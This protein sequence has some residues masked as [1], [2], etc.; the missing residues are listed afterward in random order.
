MVLAP[1]RDSDLYTALTGQLPVSV[2]LPPNKM[3]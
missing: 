2:I 3:I 1:A